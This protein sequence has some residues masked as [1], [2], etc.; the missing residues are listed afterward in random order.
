MTPEYLTWSNI[1]ARC[2]KASTRDFKQYGGKGIS[3]CA[4]WLESFEA[5][6]EDMGRR[7]SGQYSIDRMDSD[8]DYEPS[9][10][11][12][13]TAMEQ[14]SNTNRNVLLTYDG[15]TQTMSAWARELGMG[16]ETL[17]G[18]IIKGWGT[19]RALLTPVGPL[20]HNE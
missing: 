20:P 19:E 11:R 1:K 3:V 13:A 15:K 17:R 5:F 9:N 16:P 18:R 12:W 10:C 7:P 6:L 14:A 4:R 2:Y 8:G